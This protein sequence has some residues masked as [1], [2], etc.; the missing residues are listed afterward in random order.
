[1]ELVDLYPSLT[2]AGLFVAVLWLGKNVISTRLKKSVEHEFNEKL[3]TVRSQIR[4]SED[5]LKAEIR[6]KEVEIAAL[7][8]GALSA[9][10]SRQIA[11]DKRRLE[12]VDQLWESVTSL[13]PTRATLIVFS[14]IPFEGAASGVG[15]DPNARKFYQMMGNTFDISKLDSSGA[16][17]ARPFLTPMVWATFS[18]M[19][20]VLIHAVSRLYILQ[21]GIDVKDFSNIEP[22]TK[23][24]KVALPHYSKYID[25]FGTSAYY[26]VLQAL[27]EQLLSEIQIMLSGAEIDKAS[28]GLLRYF[29]SPML[30]AQRL[31]N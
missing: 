27:D 15:Q 29:S 30:L 21:S 13:A 5:R 1:M 26:N 4:D 11:L 6:I 18:A 20:A 7:R 31:L 8:N 16:S 10:A 9:L 22:V 14:A 19:Q 24:I 23:L 17:K 12:A 28:I 25:D 2:T 3:E